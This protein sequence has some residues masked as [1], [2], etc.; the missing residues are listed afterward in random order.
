M[1][2]LSRSCIAPAIIS[3]AEAEAE[4]TRTVIGMR[5]SKGSV[6]V[7]ISKTDCALLPFAETTDVPFGRNNERIFTASSTIPPPLLRKSITRCFIPFSFNPSK[8]LRKSRLPSWVNASWR[9]YPMESRNTP[10][11]D[12][13][14]I[15][16]LSRVTT[17]SFFSP[18]RPLST[19]NFTSVPGCPFIFSL[20]LSTGSGSTLSPSMAR[21]KSPGSSPY[22][23]AGEPIYGWEIS[24]PIE[25]ILRIIAPIPP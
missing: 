10:L 20:H 6:R 21:I 15:C 17:I 24:T 11:Y 16:T 14:G 7:F 5:V 23:T 25:S 8:A 19:R 22:L 13:S 12:T 3:E 1:V 4:F 9:I 2:P 18:L